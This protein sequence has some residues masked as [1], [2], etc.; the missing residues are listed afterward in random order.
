MN[1]K[2]RIKLFTVITLAI[3]FVII[4]FLAMAKT[5]KDNSKK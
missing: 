1:R 2:E 3:V 5:I 4:V